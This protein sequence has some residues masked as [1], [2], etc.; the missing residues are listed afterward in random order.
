V[1][2][3]RQRVAFTACCALTIGAGLVGEL[4][5]ALPLWLG[6]AVGWDAL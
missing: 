5:L 3:P 6:L 2:R 1:T 4:M